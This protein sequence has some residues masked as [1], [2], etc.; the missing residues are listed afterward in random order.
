MQGGY[1]GQWKNRA[2]NELYEFSATVQLSQ[3]TF[4]DVVWTAIPCTHTWSYVEAGL[5]F[6]K[7]VCSLC[8][9]NDGEYSHVW[10]QYNTAFGK[11]F[12]CKQCKKVSDIIPVEGSS[13]MFY[14]FDESGNLVTISREQAIIYMREHE[15]DFEQDIVA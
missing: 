2:T 4:F 3:A 14:I 13:L 6:H 1:T 9:Y 5:Y 8:G 12:R 11:S 15:I 7:K 10:M